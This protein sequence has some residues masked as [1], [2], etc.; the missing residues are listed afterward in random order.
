MINL[1]HKFN[2]CKYI[3]VHKDVHIS[4]YNLE[5]MYHLEY[6]YLCIYKYIVK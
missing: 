2:R 6:K 1:C 4:M 5:V 3:E